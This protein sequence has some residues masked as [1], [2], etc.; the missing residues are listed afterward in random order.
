MTFSEWMR[1]AAS[2]AMRHCHDEDA[3]FY[4]VD[5]AKRFGREIGPALLDFPDAEPSATY[6]GICVIAYNLKPPIDAREWLNSVREGM[7]KARQVK[8]VP[9]PKDYRPASVIN[10]DT[11]TAYKAR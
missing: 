4:G 9:M 5:G 3:L 8:R 6:S 2:A 10:I 7:E 1:T 11:I